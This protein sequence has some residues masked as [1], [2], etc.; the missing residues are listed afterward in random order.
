MR[1]LDQLVVSLHRD[2]G[3]VPLLVVLLWLRPPGASHKLLLL[4]AHLL[5]EVISDVLQD[6]V[7]SRELREGEGGRGEKGREREREGRGRERGMRT[8]GKRQ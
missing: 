1:Y 5:D 8:I 4:R 2:L 3:R 6:G 7:L